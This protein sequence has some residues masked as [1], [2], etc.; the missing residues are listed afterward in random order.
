MFKSK[1]KRIGIIITAVI[2][3]NTLFANNV[4]AAED[5]TDD[6][7]AAYV[8][9]HEEECV[10]IAAAPD[11][12]EEM[13][14]YSY[15][16]DKS[17]GNPTA[18]M[19]NQ[20]D[21]IALN[22]SALSAP[23]SNMNDLLSMNEDYNA[24][25][26]G[27]SLA[28]ISTSKSV[29]YVNQQS[30]SANEYYQALKSDIA[31][32][33]YTEENRK[34]Q[35]AVAVKQTVINN[36]PT[37]AFI[38]YSAFDTDNEAV[39]S[40]LSVNEPFIIKQ[41]CISGGHTYYWGYAD[42]CTG[43]VDGDDLAICANKNEWL[44]AWQIDREKKD[45][46]VVTQDKIVLE[47]SYYTP[48][49]SEV[50]LTIGTIL[51]EVPTELI[52][53]VIDY[54]GK[55]NNYVVYLPVRDAEGKYQRKI[56]LISQHYNVSEGF[57]DMTKE[58]ILKTAF[59]CIG[60]RYGWG[61]MLDSMDCS[62]YTR[63][64]YRCFG[65]SWP[66]N[67]NW[68]QTVPDIKISLADM[69]DEE[70]EKRIREL[71]AGS[72]LYFPGHT[73]IYIGNA[74]DKLYVLSAL[75]SVSEAAGELNVQKIF[76]VAL[77][78]LDVRRANG[79]TW[80]HNLQSAVC[81]FGIKEWKSGTDLPDDV[82]GENTGE[83][84]KI[85][86]LNGEI[87]AA[88]DDTIAIDAF[89]NKTNR[90]YIDFARIDGSRVRDNQLRVTVIAGSKVYTRAA[91]TSAQC[92]KSV[93]KVSVNKKTGIAAVKLKASGDVSYELQDGSK[94][95]VHYTVEKPK[96]NAALKR[97]EKGNGVKCLTV[98]QLFGTAISA[99]RLE[100]AADKYKT[101]EIDNNVLKIDTA[102]TNNIKVRYLFLN[103]KYQI[104]I[105]VK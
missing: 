65:V 14:D 87:Y 81:P 100:I 72:L 82:K 13:C 57:L 25:S 45:F 42:N 55:W 11:V 99:G 96:V 5:I 48:E 40:A 17:V 76:S 54:R 43:W 66:R 86:P 80:I 26:L 51:K 84:F 7:G 101:A 22:R 28:D 83:V 52:P 34:V 77:N 6:T 79:T 62:L 33:K 92:D 69:T 58:N 70:K 19:M 18:L 85:T 73:M 75:G 29:L 105:K 38:G 31:A 104:K 20:D 49:I 32:T 93:G 24:A 4:Q 36:I 39:N 59:T 64:V 56:A 88:V 46:L 97:L 74:G 68:Q 47:P 37:N 12:T 91:V 10:Q 61:G 35:Y 16:L 71:P 95:T 3:F 94:Y 1:S 102:K 98:S 78:A 2:M 90:L 27:A 23:G 89:Y 53:A 30:V 50:K 67:T 60:N 63:N 15:W 9:A 21:I 103:K 8:S 41:R 44:E